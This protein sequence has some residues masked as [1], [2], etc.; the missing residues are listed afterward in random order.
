MHDKV[1]MGGL[2]LP[3]SD[4]LN[5]EGC[6]PP[7]SPLQVA[8]HYGAEGLFWWSRASWCLSDLI[9]LLYMGGMNQD[10]YTGQSIPC[11]DCFNIYID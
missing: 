3:T 11:H 9:F 7:L 5:D 2:C 1:R 6:G 8:Y 4:C 10:S